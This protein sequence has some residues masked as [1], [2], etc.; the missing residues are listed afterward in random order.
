MA[1]THPIGTT[2]E[3]ALTAHVTGKLKV[4][5]R[6]P[7]MLTAPSSGSLFFSPAWF[8]AAQAGLPPDQ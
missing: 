7:T 8:P 2:S 3:G 4:V 5:K 1:E 6:I